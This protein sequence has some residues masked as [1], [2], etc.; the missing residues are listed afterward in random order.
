MQ[1]G[2]IVVSIIACRKSVPV[3]HDLIA[4]S[5][6][7][8]IVAD[9]KVVIVI[10]SIGKNARTGMHGDGTIIVT[11]VEQGVNILTMEIAIT[12][13]SESFALGLGVIIR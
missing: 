8:I 4:K 7:E 12:L 5:K 1:E 13:S 10:N 9:D 2:L 6:L 3:V 11:P